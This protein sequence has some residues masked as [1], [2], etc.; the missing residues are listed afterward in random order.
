M[1]RY[2]FFCIK[3]LK[4]SLFVYFLL[5][6]CFLP[7]PQKILKAINCITTRRTTRMLHSGGAQQMAQVWSQVQLRSSPNLLGSNWLSFLKPTWA[8]GHR[9]V[10]D[11]KTRAGLRDQ[12]QRN[13]R[14]IRLSDVENQRKQTR[15]SNYKKKTIYDSLWGTIKRSKKVAR[16][17]ISS[18]FTSVWVIVRAGE[19]KR[20]WQEDGEAIL[21]FFDLAISFLC[22]RMNISYGRLRFCLRLVLYGGG[23]LINR[24][25]SSSRPDNLENPFLRSYCYFLGAF[26]AYPFLLR[27]WL[28]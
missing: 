2:H 10:Y 4:A 27:E 11:I 25:V 23:E 7:L 5:S 1:F 13:L 14:K 28:T 22:W 15:E 3:L 6:F 26:N 24:V 18:E 8:R 16:W 9:D 19:R 17:P 12:R 20:R 21:R